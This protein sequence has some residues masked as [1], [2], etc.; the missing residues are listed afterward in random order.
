MISTVIKSLRAFKGFYDL[1]F[2][3][4]EFYVDSRAELKN[5]IGTASNNLRKSDTDLSLW[6]TCPSAFGLP[7]VVM[8][9]FQEFSSVFDLELIFREG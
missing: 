5:G 9:S 4:E 3:Q 6:Q 2:S 8:N 7:D 1:A